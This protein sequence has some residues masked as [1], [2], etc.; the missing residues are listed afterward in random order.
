M[1][2][3][4]ALSNP[5]AAWALLYLLFLLVFYF[6]VLSFSHAPSIPAALWALGERQGERERERERERARERESVRE[7]ER[8]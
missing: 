5:A 4:K 6:S 1:R 7:R 8:E 3:F 2:P